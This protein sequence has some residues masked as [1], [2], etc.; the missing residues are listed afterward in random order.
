MSAKSDIQQIRMGFLR[1][2]DSAPVILAQEKGYFAEEG[3][4][5]RLSVEPSWANIADKLAFG[6]LDAA[7]ILPPLALAM[8]IGLRGKP[9]EITVPM[10]I[11]LNGNT[12]TFSREIADALG[13]TSDALKAGQQFAAWLKDTGRKPRLAVV[14]VFSTHNLLLRYWLAASGID[15]DRDVEIEILPP[16]ETADALRKGTIDGFC[17]G[18]PWG[19]VAEASGAGQT[20]VVSSQIWRDHPEKCLAVRDDAELPHPA[21][22][23]G[24]LKG[25]AYCSDPANAAKAASILGRAEYLEVDPTLIAASLPKRAAAWCDC[26]VFTPAVASFPFRHHAVWFLKQ[27]QRWN[28]APADMDAVAVAERIY[29]PAVFPDSVVSERSEEVFFDQRRSG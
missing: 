20:V 24:I 26:P 9:V 18:A 23:A 5:V 15:A 22:V 28:Y 6:R 16:P 8:A 4:D 17:A 3:L 12:I 29:R 21:L 19:A 10:G 27:M 2:T 14:H 11:N 7:V 1:L 25:A 13:E